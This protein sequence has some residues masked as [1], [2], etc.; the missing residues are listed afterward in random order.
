MAYN[1]NLWLRRGKRNRITPFWAALATVI[2]APLGYWFNGDGYRGLKYTAVIFFAGYVTLSVATFIGSAI[3]AGDVYRVS[4]R[5]E[6]RFV[7]AQGDFKYSNLS[8]IIK[9]VMVSF[10]ILFGVLIFLFFSLI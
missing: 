3:L 7:N 1:Y 2:L 6:K 4:K 10:L 9:L 5:H 8:W